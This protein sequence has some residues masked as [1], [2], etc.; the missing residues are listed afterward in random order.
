MFNDSHT[1]CD[2]IFFAETPMFNKSPKN[3]NNNPQKKKN[4]KKQKQQQQCL[5]RNRCID[6]M[7]KNS[8]TDVQHST[9]FNAQAL[10][11][12]AFCWNTKHCKKLW[13]TCEVRAP[14]SS[15]L[16]R[17]GRDQDGRIASQSRQRTS[18]THPRSSPWRKGV[19]TF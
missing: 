9:V 3:D 4:Q 15:H 1:I 16:V 17:Y 10:L 12:T 13:C 6:A 18:R 2:V 14:T 19:L 8:S 11:S 7:F 5:I